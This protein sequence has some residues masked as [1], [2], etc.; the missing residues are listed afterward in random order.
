[1]KDRIFDPTEV[2]RL[3]GIQTPKMNQEKLARLIGASYVSVN[4]WLQGHACPGRMATNVIY[5][6][7]LDEDVF[8]GETVKR[9]LTS[10]ET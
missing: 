5:S 3:M 2:K 7:L 4:R 1:M 9:N 10:Q 8:T 6:L